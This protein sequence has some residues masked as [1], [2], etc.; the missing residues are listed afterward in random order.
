MHPQ[1]QGHPH[2]ASTFFVPPYKGNRPTPRPLYP[3]AKR[4]S[5]PRPRGVLI[6]RDSSHSAGIS[7]ML[8]LWLFRWDSTG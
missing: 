7:S 4:N 1:Q 2:G 6:L 8:A 5:T 3:A